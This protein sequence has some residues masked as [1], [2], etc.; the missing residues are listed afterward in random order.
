MIPI[1]ATLLLGALSLAAAACSPTPPEAIETTTP[2]SIFD[3][4]RDPSDLVLLVT[5]LGGPILTGFKAGRLPLFGLYADGSLLVPGN[6]VGA[7]PMIEPVERFE[8]DEQR[9][10]A[11]DELVNQIGLPSLIEKVTDDSLYGS[12]FDVGTIVATFTDADGVEH[13]YEAYGLPRDGAGGPP[14]AD[15]DWPSPQTH[16]L[17]ELTSMLY[18]LGL[19]ADGDDYVPERVQVFWLEPVLDWPAL[20]QWPFP[21]TPSGFGLAPGSDRHCVVLSGS[22]VDTA[23]DALRDLPRESYFEADGQKYWL[24]TRILLPGEAGCGPEIAELNA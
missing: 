4:N 20:Q 21:I 6:L 15:G 2:P 19:D 14:S 17:G 5:D 9:R 1:R 23:I 13:V 10:E 8:L 16:A 7:D 22:A 11:I 24:V 18:R 12:V 3:S